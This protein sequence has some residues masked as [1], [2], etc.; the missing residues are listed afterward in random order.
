M[1]GQIDLLGTLCQKIEVI[2]PG[3]TQM[4]MH[5]PCAHDANAPQEPDLRKPYTHEHH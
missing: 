5:Q 4:R 1:T 2:A 3:L